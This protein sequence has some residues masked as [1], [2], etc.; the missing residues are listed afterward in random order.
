MFEC[1]TKDRFLPERVIEDRVLGL[2]QVIDIP[3]AAVESL[4][5]DWSGDRNLWLG[6]IEDWLEKLPARL[7]G[8]SARQW[9]AACLHVCPELYAEPPRPLK[10]SDATP[11][12]KAKMAALQRRAEAGCSLWHPLDT[13]GVDLQQT[14]FGKAAG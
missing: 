1:D 6:K 12:S 14:L 2:G 7:G 8:L 11:R 4:S 13:Q 10:S 5:N 9:A 3:D